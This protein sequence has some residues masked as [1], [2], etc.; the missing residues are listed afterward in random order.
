MAN[1]CLPIGQNEK[2]LRAL[3]GSAVSHLCV[4]Q[5]I[6]YYRKVVSSS[7]DAP[8]VADR[9]RAN[10]KEVPLMRPPKNLRF[11][12]LE[13]EG[14]RQIHRTALKIL[15]EIGI[16][17]R[18]DETRGRLKD[19]GCRDGGNGYLTFEE[20]LVERSLSTVPPNLVLYDRSGNVAVDTGDPTSRFS[21]GTGCI[22]VLDFE[23]GVHRPCV[24]ED[25]VKTARVCNRLPQIDLVLSLGSPRDVPPHEEA[26]QT[27]RAIVENTA[28]PLG[29]LGHNETETGQVWQ[30]LADV[31]G[32]W[33]ALA[34]KPFAIDLTG[35]TSPLK[36]GVEASRRLRAAASRCLPVVCFPA[37][38]PGATAPMTLSGALAQTAA[39]V[40]AG[41]VVHQMERPGAPVMSGAA[42]LPVDMRTGNLCYGGPEY[43][44]ICSATVDYLGDLGVPSWSG[45][46]C[47][48][49]HTVD[50]QAAA[51]AGMNMLMSVLAGTSLTHNLGFLSSGKT[52]SLEMLV[53]CD[54]LAGMVSRIAAGVRVSEDTLAFDVVRNAGKS[55]AY[56]TEGHTLAHAR[57]ELWVPSMFGRIPLPQWTQS[58]AK[59][60]QVRLKEKLRELLNE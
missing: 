39:E 23:T 41:I 52:G 42:I 44:L 16:D 51:E 8:W 10:R 27:V 50:S 37:V 53:L 29:F 45:S 22:D 54:E 46:G 21:P 49:A 14:T 56:I 20:E 24:R 48:D 5:S 7:Y 26:I 32:S 18:D 3:S 15:R 34:E 59:S 36:L 31:A 28:K 17:V 35:P 12:V 2:T 43:A 47:S 60:Q 55:G 57:T 11:R 1:R 25:I 30:Y 4:F 58:G 6:L 9:I 40:L 38:M 19:M 33:E 13:E